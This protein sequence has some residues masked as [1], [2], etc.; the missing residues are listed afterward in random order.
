MSRDTRFPLTWL[1]GV[2]AAVTLLLPSS[3][4]A[5]AP[6]CPDTAA[7]AACPADET[8]SPRSDASQPGKPADPKSTPAA[9]EPQ[10]N[11]PVHEPVDEPSGTTSSTGD[12]STSTGSTVGPGAVPGQDG[13]AEEATARTAPPDLGPRRTFTAVVRPGGDGLALQVVV[14]ERAARGVD[15]GWVITLEVDRDDAVVTGLTTR[16]TPRGAGGVIRAGASALFLDGPGRLFGVFGQSSDRQYDGRYVA[17]GE[18]SFGADAPPDA[19]EPHT[20][21]V[22]LFQ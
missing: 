20:V 17:R 11:S 6:N 19:A 3:S 18:V 9:E 21:I 10:E 5:A 2:C 1:L 8:S 7:N 16:R 13:E 12:G 4:V 22:T 14:D 15:S